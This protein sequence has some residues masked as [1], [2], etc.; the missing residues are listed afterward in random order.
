MYPDKGVVLMKKLL[1]KTAISLFCI[2][3]GKEYAPKIYVPSIPAYTKKTHACS[4]TNSL[5]RFD[6]SENFKYMTKHEFC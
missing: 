5:Y 6:K 2:L 4:G 1:I 3:L